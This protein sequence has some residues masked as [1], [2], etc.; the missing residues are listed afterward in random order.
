[1][2]IAKLLANANTEIMHRKQRVPLLVEN[3]VYLFLHE[4]NDPDLLSP[5]NHPGIHAVIIAAVWETGFHTELDMDNVD[6]LDN[7][8]SLS[9]AATH[10]VLM[11]HLNRRHQMVEFSASLSSGAEYRLIQQHDLTICKVPAVH[12]TF[13][14]LKKDLVEQDKI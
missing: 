1:M 11:E 2:G 3:H 10:S 8:I 4:M 14:S 12:D 6:A 13:I 7:L 5:V 9:S